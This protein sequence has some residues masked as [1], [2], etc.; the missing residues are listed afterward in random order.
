V[1]KIA[2]EEAAELP[3][4]RSQRANDDDAIRVGKQ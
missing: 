3:P 2:F 4:L 1:N